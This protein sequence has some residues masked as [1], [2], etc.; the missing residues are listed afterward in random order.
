MNLEEAELNVQ[1]DDLESELAKQTRENRKLKNQI[2]KNKVKRKR[3]NIAMASFITIVSL[4]AGSMAHSLYSNHKMIR[5][6]KDEITSN[7]YE[8]CM[9]D[10]GWAW[11]SDGIKFNIGQEYFEYKEF[12]STIKARAQFCDI[13]DIDLYIAI[14]NIFNPSIA[15]DMVG[16]KNSNDVNNRAYEVYL[17]NEL[18]SVK[19]HGR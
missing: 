11:H 19:T 13:S 5:A 16:E 1:I 4:A 9:K 2:E 10:A 7:V 12:L 15:E 3:I 18:E 8:S 17:S 6:G 14:S